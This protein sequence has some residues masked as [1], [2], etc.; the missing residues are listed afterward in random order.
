MSI[1]WQKKRQRHIRQIPVNLYNRVEQKLKTAELF[2]KK[3]TENLHKQDPALVKCPKCGKM[4]DKKRVIK[5]KLVCYECGGYFR[6]STKNRIR[7]V[8]DPQTFEEW[9]ADQP[10]SNPLGYEGY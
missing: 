10:V 9:F 3:E 1:S 5:R 4:V 8:A 7:M 2:T 6:V